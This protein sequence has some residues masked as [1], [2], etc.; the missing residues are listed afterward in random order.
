MKLTILT[1]AFALMALLP[2]AFAMDDHGHD[3]SKAMDE[4]AATAVVFYSV[5]CASCKILEPR[6]M[7]AM[8]AIN[9]DNLNVVKLDFSSK[10]T[11]EA[12]KTLAAEKGVESTLQSY[13]AKT[14]FVVLLDK[15][16]NEIDK[17][18]V[19]DN[20]ADIAAKLARAIVS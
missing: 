7:E 20:T 9:K 17:L 6:M 5:N 10:E 1:M 14:G 15:E 19:D 13:G 8:Q 18:K 12:S 11:I 2:Q 16:G 4:K 3:H